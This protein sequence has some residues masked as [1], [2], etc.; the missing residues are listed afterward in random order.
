M[1]N[2]NKPVS[3]DRFLSILNIHFPLIPLFPQLV[4]SA[5]MLLVKDPGTS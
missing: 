5:A 3:T 4:S 1:L 2:K